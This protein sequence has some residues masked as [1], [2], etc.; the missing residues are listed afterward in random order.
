MASAPTPLR[1]TDKPVD[2]QV[3]VASPDALAKAAET[4]KKKNAP[5]VFAALVVLAAVGAGLFWILGHGKESTDDAQVEGRIVSVSSRVQGQVAR[6][7]VQDNQEVHEGDI[8]IEIDPKDLDAKL[9]A[10]K[11]DADAAQAQY[12]SAVAQEKLTEINAGATIRQARGGLAQASAN[13]SASRSGLQQ[14]QANIEAAQSAAQLAQQD[15]ARA[16]ELIADKT[17]PQSELDMRQSRADQSRAQLEQAK[18]SYS[19]TQANVVASSGGVEVATGR[20]TAAQTGPQQVATA[21]A[22]QAQAKARVDLMNAQLELSRLNRSYAD[23]RAPV[24]GVVSRRTVEAGQL[25][26]P[27][28]PLLALVPLHDVWVVANFKEDQIGEMAKGQRAKIHVDTY[29]KNF[30][31]KLDSIAGASGARFAL[32]PPDNASGNFIKVVQRVPVLIRFTELPKDFVLRPG[33]S[34][35]VTVYTK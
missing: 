19:S 31:G 4:P 22:A 1:A 11:A 30:E 2:N 9:A 17:I 8:L 14:G 35:D 34:A 27:S 29:G 25:V 12:D 18:A 33:M 7:L 16:R 13:A 10:A 26:D 20:L 6:V 24:S 21:K 15:L 32:L 5:R 23:V 28:R 3:P